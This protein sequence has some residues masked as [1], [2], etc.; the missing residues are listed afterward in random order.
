MTNTSLTD[1]HFS[2]LEF[3]SDYYRKHGV[4]P[5]YLKIKQ[6][7]GISREEIEN[8]FPHGLNSVYKWV[9]IPITSPADLC[10]PVPDFEVE[11]YR[12]VYLDYNATTFLRQSVKEKIYKLYDT[13]EFQG[14]PSSSTKLGKKAY[15][16]IRDSRELIADR[17]GVLPEEIIFYNGGSEANNA[18]ILGTA[19]SYQPGKGHI[20]TSPLEHNSVLKPVEFLKSLGYRISYL[21]PDSNGEISIAELE[22]LIEKD[23]IL[24]ALMYANNEIGTVNPVNEIGRIC[25][26]YDIPFFS[27]GIQ[28]LGKAGEN[29]IADGMTMMSF[30]SHKIYGPKGAGFL[31]KNKNHNIIPIIS[32]GEQESGLRAG[33]ENIVNIAATGQAVKDLFDN[34]T[35]DI[36]HM[37]KIQ[38]YFLER[39]KN[40]GIEYV[41]NGSL[42]N[43][44]PNNL[45]IGFRDVNAKALL[46]SLNKAGIYVSSGSACSSGNDKTSHVLNA[47]KADTANYGTIRF[48]FGNE[49]GESDIDYLF[50]YLP[51]ILEKLSEEK[52]V[53]LEER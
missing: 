19:F 32:G 1:K 10:K 35:D 40:S 47:I 37:R 15:E 4:G 42:N 31:Y 16:I 5:L 53:K 39:I 20:I 28:A 22:S 8:L 3:A 29:I 46:L 34:M 50:K 36:N 30:S 21:H 2:V 12:E 44:L 14:N 45:S 23:T 17:L 25:A 49:T 11:D 6:N 41:V 48:S 7:T 24:V 38:S 43:R 51:L 26:K 13:N 52:Q 18:A 27:D 9:D 33:T